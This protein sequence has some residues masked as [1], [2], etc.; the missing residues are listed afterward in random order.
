MMPCSKIYVPPN[1]NPIA[2]A[3]LNDFIESSLQKLFTGLPVFLE[4]KCH[5]NMRKHFCATAYVAPEFTSLGEVLESNGIPPAVLTNF[6]L[7]LEILTVPFSM[8][9]FP[10]YSV[11]T[12][13]M[14]SCAGFILSANQS[15]LVPNC[16]A[17]TPQGD[18]FQYPK[19]RQTFVSF[20]LGPSNALNIYA[21]PKYYNESTVTD[22]NYAP[23]CP[24]PY[25]VVPDNINDPD[26]VLIPTTGC[27]SSC[28]S[29]GI[30]TTDELQDF[31]H[32]LLSV[33]CL[34]V[35]GVGVFL[36]VWLTDKNRQKQTLII[37]FGALNF[38]ISV[39]N[40][41]FYSAG[42]KVLCRNN[43]VSFNVNDG[44]TV[45]SVQI[46]M[47]L[48]FHLAMY[49]TWMFIAVDV[50]LKVI[51]GLM[52]SEKYYKFIISAVLLLPLI[53][54]IVLAV[55]YPQS[56]TATELGFCWTYLVPD[57]DLYLLFVPALCIISIGFVCMFSVV[58]H[59]LFFNKGQ[60]LI[61]TLKI[62]ILFVVIFLVDFITIV[63]FRFYSY[64]IV[65]KKIKD[66]FKVFYGC[67]LTN[68]NGNP[69]S[70]INCGPH[71]AFRFPVSRYSWFLFC[72]IGEGIFLSLI[73]MSGHYIRWGSA[74]A[75][76]TA[77]IIPHR[78]SIVP[79]Q[80]RIS[81]SV[82]KQHGPNVVVPVE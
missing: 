61:S 60:D 15:A 50:F 27:A 82:N 4:S 32:M 14:S 16:S 31:N 34:S 42:S 49:L 66:A 44:I 36:A 9:H 33:S 53:P 2:T 6:G 41:A 52:K 25:M 37:T 43:A 30:Y 59:I 74:I 13:Y 70:V 1:A 24:G 47:I 62:P 56:M 5:F 73:F 35:V 68:F 26:L 20:S 80:V 10:H 7:P 18:F 45:C 63:E 71:I 22:S 57:L 76:R 46:F 69:N 21:H 64:D 67:L 78:S 79:R 48:Y 3:G 40:V 12:D 8:P 51:W 55:A 29:K 75:Y 81:H 19:Q 17:K 23:V 38:V 28:V 58:I 72:F 77:T 65:D 54:V 11:C 39:F